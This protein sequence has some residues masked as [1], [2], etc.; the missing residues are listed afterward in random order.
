MLKTDITHLLGKEII[1]FDRSSYSCVVY[2][3][4][5]GEEQTSPDD[6]ALVVSWTRVEVSDEFLNARHQVNTFNSETNEKYIM[7]ALKHFNNYQRL[8][9][10]Y[11]FKNPYEYFTFG[12]VG[13]RYGEHVK[14]LAEKRQEESIKYY[15]NLK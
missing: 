12:F 3:V 11:H 10:R 2:G 15:N 6:T 13:T 8:I 4:I 14:R 1:F 7:D 9:R 5:I